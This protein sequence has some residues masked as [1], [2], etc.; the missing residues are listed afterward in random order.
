MTIFALIHILKKYFALDI[1]ELLSCPLLE[2][3]S[4]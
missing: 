2:H 4:K 3:V 1:S